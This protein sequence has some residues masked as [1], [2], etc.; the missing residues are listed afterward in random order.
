MSN[1]VPIL[2]P[3]EDPWHLES[4]TALRG[5]NLEKYWKKSPPWARPNGEA[6][7]GIFYIFSKCQYFHGFQVPYADPLLRKLI[8]ILWHIPRGSHMF[9]CVFIWHGSMKW[10]YKSHSLPP[11]SRNIQNDVF[12]NIQKW[13]CQKSSK[14]HVKNMKKRGPKRGSKK[15]SKIVKNPEKKHVFLQVSHFPR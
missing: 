4:Q 11:K 1:I 10:I 15:G 9:Q 5:E 12:E 13:M 7:F 8:E 6:F 3:P 14:K 2:K